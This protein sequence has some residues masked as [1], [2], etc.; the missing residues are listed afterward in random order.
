MV[1]LQKAEWG[2]CPQ[3]TNSRIF[4]SNSSDGLCRM[5]SDFTSE[6]LILSHLKENLPL[7]SFCDSSLEHFESV[8]YYSD[9][10]VLWM[11]LLFKVAFLGYFSYYW[12]MG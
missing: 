1:T 10:Q 5:K 2:F 12:L 3:K 11:H 8:L 7:A 6:F 4:H 9:L